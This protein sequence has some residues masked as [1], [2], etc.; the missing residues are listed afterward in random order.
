MHKK[1]HQMSEY[2]TLQW[3]ANQGKLWNEYLDIALAI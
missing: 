1:D 3:K 2:P